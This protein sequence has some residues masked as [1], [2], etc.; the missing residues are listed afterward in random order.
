MNSQQLSDDGDILRILFAII[1]EKLSSKENATQFAENFIQF[2]LET[3]KEKYSDDFFFDI[4]K[5]VISSLIR[6]KDD[7][8]KELRY[9]NDFV[10]DKSCENEGTAYAKDILSGLIE[11]IDYILLN[12]DVRPFTSEDKRF[13]SLRQSVVKK[14]ITDSPELIKTVAESLSCGYER[15]GLVISKERVVAYAPAEA[16]VNN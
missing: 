7:T 14:I 12:Y 6:L 3:S 13:N 1:I 5:P 2:F 8:A 16:A 10:S 9:Y 4:I 15:N 11:S